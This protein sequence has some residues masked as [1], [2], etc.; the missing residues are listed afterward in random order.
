MKL[1]LIIPCVDKKLTKIR[2][3]WE[4]NPRKDST[5]K[6]S[7][8]TKKRKMLVGSTKIFVGEDND[9]FGG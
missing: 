3:G 2:E 5:Q 7:S 9:G 8:L 4:R 6:P 1:I